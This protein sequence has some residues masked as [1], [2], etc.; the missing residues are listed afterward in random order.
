MLVPRPKRGVIVALIAMSLAQAAW[1]QQMPSL[2]QQALS[3]QFPQVTQWDVRAIGAAP[4]EAEGEGEVVRLGRRSAIRISDGSL[5][6][7]QVSG[8]A[9]ALVSSRALRRGEAL[10]QS[11]VSPR[12]VDVMARDCHWLS[13]WPEGGPWRM[14]RSAE[15]GMALCGDDLESIPSVLRGQSV[16]L[17]ATVNGVTV[18]V[19]ALAQADARVGERVLVRER[20]GGR[21][22]AGVVTASAEVNVDG[23]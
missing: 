3:A 20:S 1:A 4:D 11:D 10:A 19:P 5:R 12:N 8:H 13:Q 6:W 9:M 15:A 17:S 14:T 2:L 21:L 18:R 16:Q 7:Y 23:R 22:V